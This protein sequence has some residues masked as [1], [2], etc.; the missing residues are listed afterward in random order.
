MSDIEQPSDDAS[1]E[2]WIG[3]VSLLPDGDEFALAWVRR[4]DEWLADACKAPRG[5]EVTELTR[6][7]VDAVAKR[8]HP[9]NK[10]NVRARAHADAL[11]AALD[12]S[13]AI[14][15]GFDTRAEELSDAAAS[16]VDI[17]FGA[18]DQVTAEDEEN[19]RRHVQAHSGMHDAIET[20]LAQ[21][22][23]PETAAAVA[24]LQSQGLDRDQAIHMIAA[25]F[26]RTMHAALTT[27]QQFDMDAYVVAL[28]ELERPR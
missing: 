24:R 27:G 23:P 3:V 15:A 26:M 6:M 12:A 20:Q 16:A 14:E 10:L 28:G 8:G 2:T 4:S 19:H 1:V 22:D 5:N 17:A 13:V 25:L 21:N 18:H 9:P 11:T 7:Y